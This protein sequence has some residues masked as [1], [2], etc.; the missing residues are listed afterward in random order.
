MSR[1][2]NTQPKY[3][4]TDVNAGTVKNLLQ[5]IN[6]MSKQCKIQNNNDDISE[7]VRSIIYLHRPHLLSRHDL[8]VPE[9]LTEALVFNSGAPNQ[10]THNFN[11]KYDYNT[12]VPLQQQQQQPAPPLGLIDQFGMPVQPPVQNYYINPVN[13]PASSSMSFPANTNKPETSTQVDTT[14][15]TTMS[16]VEKNSLFGN[17]NNL[18]WR[19]LNEETI[20]MDMALRDANAVASVASFKN[21]ISVMI[22]TA[23]RHVAADVFV[24]SLERILV[25]DTIVQSDL[26]ILIKCINDKLG[27]NINANSPELCRLFVSVIDGYVQLVRI[28]THEQFDNLFIRLAS[29]EQIETNTM[30]VIQECQRI[31]KERDDNARDAAQLKIELAAI[32]RDLASTQQNYQREL[33]EYENVKRERAAAVVAADV[34]KN[35]I[36]NILSSLK[37]LTGDENND[38]GDAVAST[39]EYGTGLFGENK[40]GLDDTETRL[41][42]Y[43]ARI[44]SRF[45]IYETK[46][47]AMSR[48][49]EIERLER[50]INADDIVTAAEYTKQID[51]MRQRI[52]RL[53][54]DNAASE[55]SSRTIIDFLKRDNVSI[56]ASE[57]PELV[58]IERYKSIG[59]ELATAQSNLKDAQ[60]NAESRAAETAKLVKDN[61]LDKKTIA[62]MRADME[63]LMQRVER[64]ETDNK[65]EIDVYVNENAALKIEL[66]KMRERADKNAIEVARLESVNATLIADNQRDYKPKL[67]QNKKFYLE[68][69]VV[70]SAEEKLRNKLLS[71]E[72]LNQ[73][74]QL[75]IQS[76]KETLERT[77][78]SSNVIGAD[79][80]TLTNKINANKVRD[81]DKLKQ[82]LTVASEMCESTITA[83]AEEITKNVVNDI[84]NIKL[85]LISV[86]RANDAVKKAVAEYRTE[87]ETLARTAAAAQITDP[88]NRAP[89][90]VQNYLNLKIDNDDLVVS[91]TNE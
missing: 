28:V 44:T 38:D 53:E 39:I 9:L 90:V 58:L 7:R 60:S 72:N 25:F 42:R 23:R 80:L 43:V 12:N 62:S 68:P 21:L 54:N 88:N 51:M 20:E 13:V 11:Y 24:Y 82:K 78:T 85:N 70:D 30:A 31:Q 65:K 2:R 22:R 36:L 47:A 73:Q 14:A 45:N 87:Y 67:R 3:I 61:E 29:V 17:Q 27:M 75:D 55:R 19:L 8:Q 10:I 64:V 91:S 32:S 5:T 86:E 4:N 18:N 15:P 50:N 56:G 89:P 63:A 26:R 77:M 6:S 81:Y 79:F 34:H 83:K 33:I 37:N 16:P 48:Q 74:L 46:L 35:Q 69:T 84:E 52:K 66:E 1:Y 71:S 76:I 57:S 41:A 49:R 59:V 40:N